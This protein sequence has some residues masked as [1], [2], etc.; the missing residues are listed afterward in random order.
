MV[1]QWTGGGD[2]DIWHVE[3]APADP[4]ERADLCDEYREDAD[5]AFGSVEIV[6]AAKPGSRSRAGPPGGARDQRAHPPRPHPPVGRYDR[7][8]GVA[9]R[10]A[11][12][13]LAPDH[14]ERCPVATF[15]HPTPERCAQL[16]R[17]LTAA[18]LD[19]SDNGRQD[20]P[21]FLTY[22]VTDPHGRMWQVSPATNFLRPRP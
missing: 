7:S 8:P 22:T 10:Q 11:A 3:E 13:A 16:G 4:G 14:E 9:Y 15:A 20:D 6:Y 21:Q 1:G 19:W 17:A 2:V 5:N 18:G 12:P